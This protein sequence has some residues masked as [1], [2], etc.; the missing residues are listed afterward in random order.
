MALEATFSFSTHL[1]EGWGKD[2]FPLE[3]KIK[4]NSYHKDEKLKK[5]ERKINPILKAKKKFKFMQVIKIKF[6]F[7]LTVTN[8]ENLGGGGG[9]GNVKKSSTTI[10]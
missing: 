8:T 1:G 10:T 6:P 7:S 2:V 9:G 5:P 3:E 4:C